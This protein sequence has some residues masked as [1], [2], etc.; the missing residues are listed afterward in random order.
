MTLLA[1]LAQAVRNPWAPLYAVLLLAGTVVPVHFR[2]APHPFSHRPF[3]DDVLAN[4]VLFAPFG[5]LL[6]RLPLWTVLPAASAISFGIELFQQW[7]WRSPGTPDIAANVLGA[8]LGARPPR[9]L[10]RL[11]GL[12]RE[13]RRALLRGLVAVPPAIILG[14]WLLAGARPGGGF[15]NWE[16]M[17]LLVGNE[18]DAD[19]PFEGRISGIQIFD[20]V[21][22]PGDASFDGE[23]A[24]GDRG[25]PVL[26]L[27]VDGGLVLGLQDEAGARSLH[28]VDLPPRFR[29]E[30]G[31]LRCDGGRLELPGPAA[32][33]LF[34]ALRRG[35]ALSVAARIDPDPAP[36]RRQ[37]R[38][39]TMSA[40][41]EERCF[42]L[43]LRDG[44]I[45]F[46]VRSPASGPN[47]RFPQILGGRPLPGGGPRTIL[48]TYDRH[49]MRAYVD[50]TLAESL[51]LGAL[52]PSKAIGHGL[53]LLFAVACASSALAAGAAVKSRARLPLAALLA[54]AA[55]LL[56]KGLEVDR[57]YPPL[58]LHF[59]LPSLLATLAAL[60]TV[61]TGGVDS[62]SAAGGRTRSD[63]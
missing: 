3:A 50:G 36:G 53:P 2:T 21:V 46:R 6:R 59:G 51:V 38:I 20:R 16:P 63:E 62:G 41:A 11:A 32:A 24:P 34:E 60:R 18:R 47:G 9:P 58:P 44:R 14:G 40:G 12:L 22:A 33:R 61:A 19:R 27:R 28:A 31:A 8:W 48:C 7:T 1:R 52:I 39:V 42:T 29:I 55:F 56:L 54:L 49:R 25:G 45:V 17:P 15:E 30:D 23:P 13:R 5:L 57:H 4:I 26:F 10:R 43:G 35:D 37:S